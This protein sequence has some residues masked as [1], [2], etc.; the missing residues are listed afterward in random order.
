M[1]LKRRSLLLGLGA[2]TLSSLL[3]SCRSQT[4][5]TLRIQMLENSIP[6]Q[7]FKQFQRQL[8]QRMALDV[9]PQPQL[10]QLYELLLTWKKSQTP[11]QTGGLPSWV[12]LVGTKPPP[13]VVDLLTLGD[14]WLT[15]AIAQG[16]VA[17]FAVD[18][19]KGLQQLDAKFQ[20]IVRRDDQGQLDPNGKLWAAPYRWG[21]TMIAYRTQEF[22]TLGGQPT[23]W[24]DLWRP[25]LQ[26]RISVLDSP[27]ETIGLV[28][29]ELGRSV[30]S[31]R[32]DDAVESQLTALHRQVKFYSSNAYIEPLLLGDTWAAVGWSTDILPMVAGDRRIAAV[33]PASGTILSADLWVRPV[34]AAS[35]S[36]ATE[37]SLVSQWIDFCWQPDTA[38]QLALLGSSASPQLARVNRNTLPEPLQK[39]TALLPSI[40]IVENSEFLQPLSS[41][42]LERYRQLWANVR[43]TG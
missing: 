6:V 8:K 34:G 21:T 2:L 20:D 18:E 38:I 43:Q 19:L 27:R 29:K 12:P 31:D 10:A 24:S 23:D 40:D 7:L 16:L 22:E 17:P 32:L 14:Y 11:D 13:E 42:T 41:A 25:E 30:N 5:P 28:L 35:G 26:G 1:S 4:S 33:V 15:T 39:N 36:S 3:P 37:P 9:V